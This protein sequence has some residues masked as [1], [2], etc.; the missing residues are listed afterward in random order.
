[1]KRT[2]LSLIFLVPVLVVTA[3]GAQAEST[4]TVSHWDVIAYVGNDYVSAV[5]TL[6]RTGDNVS[7]T[8]NHNTINGK[9]VDD[10]QQLNG[11]WSGPRGSGWITLHYSNGGNGFHGTWGQ[12]GKPADGNLVGHRVTPS[13]APAPAST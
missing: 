10:G 8:F 7:G 6:H 5:M 11:T 2:L 3:I 1:M 4:T 9:I 12:K 13:P